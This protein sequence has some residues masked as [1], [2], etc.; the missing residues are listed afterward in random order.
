MAVWTPPELE[1][2]VGKR[3]GISSVNGPP[4]IAKP[5]REKMLAMAPADIGRSLVAITPQSVDRLQ[6]IQ[7]VSATQED[8]NDLATAVVAR[9]EGLDYILRGEVIGPRKHRIV[10]LDSDSPSQSVPLN[11]N[12]PLRVSW[13]LMSV[14]DNRHCGG[15]PVVIDLETARKRYPDLAVLGNDEQLLMGASVREA[16]RLITP[17][18]KLQ[19]VQLAVIFGLP[20]GRQL[21]RGNALAMQGQWSEAEVEW[22]EVAGIVG[23]QVAAFHNLALAAAAAQ[24]FSKAKRLARKAVRRLPTPLHKKTL[25]WIEQRQRDYHKSFNLPDPPEG[26]YV[27]RSVAD[28]GPSLTELRE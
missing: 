12:E 7:L 6:T 24:D 10:P 20:G 14:T 21:R 19:R 25:V 16:Y 11:L 4:R 3:V 1:S 8:P 26:W 22:R 2:A 27:S 18:T 5:L 28:R 9:R 23:A 15:K 13:R 17:S